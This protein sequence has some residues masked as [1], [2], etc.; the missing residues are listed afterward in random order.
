MNVLHL[1][2][3]LLREK[4]LPVE[5]V[6]DEIR[7]LAEYMFVLME[8]ENGVG[9]AAPQIGKLIRMFVL[10]ADDEVKRVFI[11][12]QIIKTSTETC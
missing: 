3:P 4:S 11:N 9:L 6:T 7:Q 2:N 8:Q 5:Q 1:G 12:P 10:T